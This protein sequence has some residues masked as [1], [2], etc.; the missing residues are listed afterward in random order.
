MILNTILLN[1][2]K[3]KN[4]LLELNLFIKYELH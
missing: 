2:K 1:I 4:E 3:K